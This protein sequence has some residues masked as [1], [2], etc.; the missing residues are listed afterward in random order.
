MIN[1]RRTIATISARMG[2]TR[3]PGKVLMPLSGEPVLVRIVERVSRSKYFDDIVIA[4][5]TN[6]GD[7][8]IEAFCRERG[9]HCYRGS[10]DDVLAR[11]Y[12]AAKSCDADIVYRG[13]GDSPLVDHRI[14]DD[15]L[16]K[17]VEGNY[18][19]VSNEMGD[20][21]SP[22]GV[23]ATVFTLK[24]LEDGYKE[25]THPEMRE[26]VTVHIKTNSKRYKILALKAEGEMIF[27]GL[28][29]TLDTAQ[30]YEVL[31][32]VFDELYPKDHDFSASDVIDFLQKRPD[33]VNINSEVKQ[34]VPTLLDQEK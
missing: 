14:V 24:A 6:P 4:T 16:E 7:D 28:R 2:S 20:V 34:K 15:L 17:L 30:D 29:L 9:Y 10:E 33:I 5:S 19:F 27:P 21:S 25:A 31:S 3:L 8:K 11:V 32:A 1:G 18:D 23:D 22:D 26:H 13:M 12:E